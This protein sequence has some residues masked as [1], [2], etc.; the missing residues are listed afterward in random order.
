VSASTTGCSRGC[1]R[2]TGHQGGTSHRSCSDCVGQHDD[3]RADGIRGVVEGKGKTAILASNGDFNRD[4]S[5]TVGPVVAA[6]A[7]RQD[8]EISPICDISL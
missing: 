6:L 1:D 4:S 8:R 3:A 2:S 5:V 7:E